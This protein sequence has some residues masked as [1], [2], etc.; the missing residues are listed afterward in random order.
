M[1]E[2]YNMDTEAPKFAIDLSMFLHYLNAY[3]RLAVYI[4]RGTEEKNDEYLYACVRYYNKFIKIEYSK[5]ELPKKE[6]VIVAK[7]VRR[8]NL[9]FKVDSQGEFV[10][11]ED[12]EAKR[13][14]LDFEVVDF[15]K[16]NNINGAL[17]YIHTNNPELLTKVPI[18]FTL[19][20]KNEYTTLLWEHLRVMFYMSQ[21]LLSSSS[22]NINA[23][24]VNDEALNHIQTSLEAIAK[25]E[26]LLKV[27]KV[28]GTDKFLKS[29]L[30]DPVIESSEDVSA[31][32][33]EAM[34]MF[35]EKGLDKNP[36][37]GKI[38][39]SVTSELH[40]VDLSKGNMVQNMMSIASKVAGEITKENDISSLQ[41]SMG[42]IGEIF[43]DFLKDDK[44]DKSQLPP[45]LRSMVSTMTNMIDKVGNVD[46]PVN[47][48]S[49]QELCEKY[50]TDNNLNRDE[51]LAEVS[52]GNGGIDL[53]KFEEYVM[54]R[55][56][57]EMDDSLLK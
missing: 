14:P 27:D 50:I 40:S 54:S 17:Q 51:V 10:N 32:K 44:F 45:S 2:R 37:I 19:P 12:K 1:L 55:V 47:G 31:A 29:N 3:L 7:S 4:N 53:S 22:S 49:I 56:K 26:K 35:K 9:L 48:A 15:M 33:E 42:S 41:G 6:C 5:R 28:L 13:S 36:L 16:N 21:S 43:K 11:L 39:E 46:Q 38:L 30:D 20:K 23:E 24:A 8:I 57:L 52:D 34:K 25:L 18:A